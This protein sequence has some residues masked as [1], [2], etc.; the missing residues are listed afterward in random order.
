MGNWVAAKW[1]RGDFVTRLDVLV[2]GSGS[3]ASLE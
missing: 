3:V 1:C 2:S